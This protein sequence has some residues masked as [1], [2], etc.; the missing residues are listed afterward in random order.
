MSTRKY[1]TIFGGSFFALGLIFL[2][3]GLYATYR[4]HGDAARLAHEGQV[5]EGIV[6]ERKIETYQAN[7]RSR[8]DYHLV[9]RF[10]TADG[11][12]LTDEAGVDRATWDRLVERSPVRISYVPGAPDINALVGHEPEWVFALIVPAIGFV[13]T[14]LGGF[15]LMRLRGQESGRLASD[16][17]AES[18]RMGRRS[19]GTAS[20]SAQ[21]VHRPTLPPGT[22]R[23]LLLFGAFCFLVPLLLL[24]WICQTAF[25]EW[26]YAHE[27]AAASCAVTGKSIEQADASHNTSTRYQ[28]HCQFATAAGEMVEG[29]YAL[30]VA[31]WELLTPGSALAIT[32]LPADPRRSR[33]AGANFDLGTAGVALMI[34][35][36]LAAVFLLFGGLCLQ[37]ARRGPWRE[38][39]LR[40]P[41]PA[42]ALRSTHRT[43]LRPLA[44]AT[45]ALRRFPRLDQ[46][47]IWIPAVVVVSALLAAPLADIAAMRAVNS[48]LDAHRLWL[49][50]PAIPLGMLGFILFLGSGLALL[51]DGKPLSREELDAFYRAQ[52]TGDRRD[53]GLSWRRQFAADDGA[54]IAA[55]DTFTLADLKHAWHA[56]LL[57]RP[58]FPRRLAK[59]AGGIMLLLS[60]A[61]TVFALGDGVMR[62]WAAVWALLALGWLVRALAK[63]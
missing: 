6:I 13:L 19:P 60:V 35:I 61:G 52:G 15:V 59:L 48:F 24:G 5:A 11:Q 2:F 54:V 46:R 38:L 36:P 27:G 28:V 17:A 50:V 58:P 32:Y 14:T 12:T 30:P 23:L 3:A 22:R 39:W 47:W 10:T 44:A 18:A 45:P 63:P 8:E 42:P 34:L 25:E 29:H 49:L 26:R 20:D 51:M 57:R 7:G 53:P 56:G 1:W 41:A 21:A 4:A 9:Y 16:V 55:Y 31:A 62:I 43:T 37:R 40:P 33:L